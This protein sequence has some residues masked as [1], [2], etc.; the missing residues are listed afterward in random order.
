MNVVRAGNVAG[1]IGMAS[2]SLLL[3]Y[4]GATLDNVERTLF[5]ITYDARW[6]YIVAGVIGLVALV[7]RRAVMWW[8]LAMTVPT[9][10]RAVTLWIDG[11][12]ALSRPYEVR[13]ALTWLVLWIMGGLSAIVVEGS[14][15][16]TRY[17]DRR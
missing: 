4:T 3:I 11:S 12:P 1:H 9:L 16:L 10:G 13:G 5:S 2:L 15:S 7:W 8:A 6:L 17:L 14:A